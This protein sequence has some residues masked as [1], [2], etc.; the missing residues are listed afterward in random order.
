M[1]F[2]SRLSRRTLQVATLTAV[3]LVV[4]ALLFVDTVNT[5]RDTATVWVITH[6]VP[7]GDLIDASAVRV[8]RVPASGASSAFT[9]VS[10]VGKVAAHALSTGDVARTDDFTAAPVVTVP[11]RLGGYQ[12][13]AGDSIDIYFTQD[14]RV[15]L[16]GRGVA[17]VGG[18]AIQVPASDEALWVALYGSSST[19]IATRSS[20]TGVQAD[21]VSAAE[22]ARELGNVAAGTA[23]R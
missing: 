2:T 11:V 5:P 21:P 1:T 12:P 23:G 4:F 3:L 9:A 10:P 7:A 22:A 19:L 8:M 18:S 14:G 15:T 6:S 20:G 13:A 17:Y 16:I